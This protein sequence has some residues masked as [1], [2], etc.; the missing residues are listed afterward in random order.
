[1]F[2]SAKT[3]KVQTSEKIIM[4]Y[5]N[6]CK[7]EA[8]LMVNLQRESFFDPRNP[9]DPYFRTGRQMRSNMPLYHL[10]YENPYQHSCWGKKTV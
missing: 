8:L 7:T 2:V 10:T 9:A 1:M 4:F 3:Q 6:S 5:V